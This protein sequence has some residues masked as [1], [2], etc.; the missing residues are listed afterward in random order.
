MRWISPMRFNC[1]ILFV[2]DVFNL[3][4]IFPTLAL[5]TNALMHTPSQIM[6]GHTPGFHY[7]KFLDNDFKGSLFMRFKRLIH[8]LD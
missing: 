2:D 4:Y 5:L 1:L 7:C 3:L 6:R 8:G